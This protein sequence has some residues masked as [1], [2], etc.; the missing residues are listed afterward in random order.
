[1]KFSYNWL[2]ELV[3]IQETPEKLAE[4]LT[5]HSFETKVVRKADEIF[6]DADILPNR[7]HDVLSH[8]DLAREIGALLGRKAEKLD[9]KFKTTSKL[10]S[11]DLLKVTVKDSNLNPRYLAW[12]I[13]N[14]KIG[15]SPPWLS[16][17][18]ETFGIRSHNLVV[19][20]LNYI[21]LE[22]GQP[23]HAFD[24]DKLASNAEGKKEIIVRRARHGEKLSALDGASFDLDENVLII[25]DVVGPIAIAGIKGGASTGIS[26]QTHRLV[27]ESAN[28]DDQAIRQASKLLNLWTDAS[29]R[30]S[31]DIDPNLAELGINRA[32]NLLDSLGVGEVLKSAVD[33]YPKKFSARTIKLNIEKL[34]R[35]IGTKLTTWEAANFLKNQ[36]FEI[37]KSSPQSLLVKVPTQRLDLEIEEDLVEEVARLKG[38]QNLKGILPQALIQTAAFNE[39]KTVTSKARYFLAHQG[40]SETLNYSFIGNNDILNFD[41]DETGLWELENPANSESQFLRSSLIPNLVKNIGNNFRFFPKVSFFEIGKVFGKAGD[42]P[43]ELLVLSGVSALRDIKEARRGELFYEIKGIL[44]G[45]LERLG[46]ADFFYDDAEPRSLIS[47]ILIWHE[48]RQAEV[49]LDSETVGF[50]GEIRPQ[51]LARVGIKGRVVAFELDVAKLVKFARADKDYQGVA[52]YP[53]VVRDLSILVDREVRVSD[54]LNAIYGAGL[55]LIGDV[56]LFDFYEEEDLPEGKKSLAFHIVY[57]ADRTLTD[58]EVEKEEEKIKKALVEKFSAEVR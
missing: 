4:V 39:E 46:V 15:S 25:A 49:K 36:N 19:D 33:F 23:M 32:L 41:L 26:E 37:K 22:M 35:L 51:V 54:I 12:V 13:D 24:F 53:S 31:Q 1:M 21:M 9:L 48:G 17:R 38:Y 10:K 3:E 57:Q 29:L 40:F 34:N 11:A 5:L 16:S 28:F 2:K 58:E 6:L 20:V 30:F 45:L 14:V 42:E 55:N 44:D 7:S 43:K 18:L 8:L 27:I 50:L 52:K 47:P 56:D